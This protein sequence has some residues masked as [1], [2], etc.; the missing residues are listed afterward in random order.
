M[1]ANQL[2][3]FYRPIVLGEVEYLQFYLFALV[4]VAVFYMR[5][6]SVECQHV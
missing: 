6:T 3:L 2:Q 4:V 5:S 1:K